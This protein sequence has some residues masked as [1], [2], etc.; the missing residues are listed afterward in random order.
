MMSRAVNQHTAT[1]SD[2]LEAVQRLQKDIHRLD[3]KVESTNIDVIHWMIGIAF[4][5][6]AM[7]I[8]LIKFVNI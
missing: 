7:T 3:M 1:K 2:L 4:A 5:Q 6:M 8:A